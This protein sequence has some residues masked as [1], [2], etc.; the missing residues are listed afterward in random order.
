[1]SAAEGMPG[2]PALAN[3]LKAFASEL[4]ANELAIWSKI[5]PVLDA[6]EGLE[7]ALLKHPPTPLLEAWIIKKICDLLI[8]RERQIM[9][10]VVRNRHM[11]RLSSFLLKV[12]KS[13][14]GLPIVTPNYDRLIE[15]A[16]EIAGFHVDTTATGHYAGKFDPA[17]SCMAS[18]QGVISR[19]KTTILKHSPRAI[20]L[21][22]HGSFDWYFDGTNAMRCTLELDGEKLSRR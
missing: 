22:P 9:Q 19:G 16:C 14:N 5:T 20:V 8:P 4:T 13:P 7:A 3:H 17:R 21:K 10:E 18:C 6:G 15:L 1:M 11:L 12:M 2:M